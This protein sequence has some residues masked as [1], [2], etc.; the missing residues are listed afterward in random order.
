VR[1]EQPSGRQHHGIAR[2]QRAQVIL[3]DLGIEAEWMPPPFAE[4]LAAL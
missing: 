1:I 2:L 3:R 4:R